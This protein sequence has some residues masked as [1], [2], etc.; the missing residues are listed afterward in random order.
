MNTF[1]LKKRIMMRIYLIF[2]I[3]KIKEPL[4]FKILVLAAALAATGSLVSLG[5]IITN[6]PIEPVALFDFGTTAFANTQLVV[7]IMTL[8]GLVTG[9]FLVRDYFL[10][11]LSSMRTIS[12]SSN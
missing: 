4:Y 8:V 11:Y 1:D 7:K 12:S 10:W 3:R 9:T 2:A 5:S 6:M